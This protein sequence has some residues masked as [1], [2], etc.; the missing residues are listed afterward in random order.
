VVNAGIAVDQYLRLHRRRCAVRHRPLLGSQAAAARR[1]LCGHRR[2]RPLYE[3]VDARFA[4]PRLKF[5]DEDV[6]AV[7]CALGGDGG[8]QV[9]AL[10][11]AV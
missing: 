8:E 3:L 5:V 7:R 10:A 6:H 11:A 4:P 9:E 1:T 2:Q